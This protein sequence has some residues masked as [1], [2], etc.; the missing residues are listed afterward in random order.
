VTGTDA[1]PVTTAVV[2]SFGTWSTRYFAATTLIAFLACG[3]VAQGITARAVYSV[4]RDGVLPGSRLLR[5]VNRRHVP[6][7]AIA[8]T[9]AVAGAGLLL[10]L[11]STAIGSLI[12]FGTAGI[13]VTFLLITVAALVA[14]LRATWQPSGFVR[15]G[16]AG[17]VW[18]VLAV[19]WL[20]FES[21]NIA[22][23]RRSIA[24]PRAP[25]YQ[26]WAAVIVL[27][28]IAIVG[29]GYLLLAKPH[30]RFPRGS[31]RP[32]IDPCSSAVT[33]RWRESGDF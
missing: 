8:F 9:T 32:T 2:T 21:V 33:P 17:I 16:R 29:L 11:R 7:W 27:A 28:V 12:A 14:R 18:N 4:A 26:V 15:L 23:P 19:A 10:G 6:L 3:M 30:R 25:W 5:T 1:D 22:W 20:A 13:Y 31:V 24:P